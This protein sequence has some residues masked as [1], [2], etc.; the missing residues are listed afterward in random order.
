MTFWNPDSIRAACSGAWLARPAM[1]ELPK[2]R[3]ADMPPPPPSLL[4]APISG[5]S[6]DTRTIKPGQVF[7]A[8]RGPN[9]DGHN[10]LTAAANG[11]SPILVIDDETAI[12]AGGFEPAVGVL[13][14]ADTGRA[15]LRLAAA[16]R[17]TLDRTK[18]IAVC[19]SNGKTTTAGLI[20]QVLSASLRGTASAKSFNNA[21][22]VPLTILAA[23]PADQ[24]LVCE[25]GTNAPGEIA[26]LAEVVQ[27]D[28]AVITS[29]G[30]E[31]LEGLGDVAGVAREE[32]SVV[33][34]VREKGCVVA[35]ADA[36]ELAE[37][38]RAAPNLVTFGRAEGATLRLTEARHTDGPDLAQSGQ[39][40]GTGPGV[41][42]TI[43]Q[44]QNYYLP[45]LGEHNALNA[46]AAIAVARRMGMAEEKIAAALAQAKAPDMRL[47]TVVVRTRGGEIHVLN[48]AYNANPDSMIAALR[49]LA[50]LPAER[51][52]VAILGDMREL[53]AAAES[54][55][56]EVARAALAI[57]GIGLAVL[58]GPNMK[59]AAEEMRA[60][61]SSARV[62]HVADIDGP[63]AAAVAAMLRPGDTVLLKGSRGMKMERLLAP[64]REAHEADAPPARP[65]RELREP[66]AS[67]AAAAR[68]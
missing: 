31:H 68:R 64:I 25:V 48:D 51:R 37:H 32:A 6:T 20:S 34:F 66:A 65:A 23:Q 28:I 45:I 43:N 16:Y 41:K 4:H 15:L 56:R 18:V 54:L 62:E 7:I 42:F 35:T 60:G 5:V 22:G 2:D 36:P 55:H 30:R 59:A 12:P 67:V 40:R 46:I 27:P 29:I 3:P 49:T 61:R 26:A 24:Y 38:L 17:K 50:A 8:L 52:R 19:G 11:G 1:I 21:I 58:V 9:H 39:V 57:D 10:F 47:Q 44:K 63:Q 13:K 53:G 33:R 14:V